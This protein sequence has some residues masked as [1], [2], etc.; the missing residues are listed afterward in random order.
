MLAQVKQQTLG[1][2]EQADLRLQ[3]AHQAEQNA[4]AHL[5]SMRQ[6]ARYPPHNA[7]LSQHTPAQHLST[8]AAWSLT[9]F[10]PLL[11]CFCG[12]QRHL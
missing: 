7:P 10:G 3:E 8:A 9:H 11:L 5:Q 6:D 1:E 4:L 2:R 12:A